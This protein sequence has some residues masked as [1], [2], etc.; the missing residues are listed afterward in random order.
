MGTRLEP[1][2]LAFD[3]SL[4]TVEQMVLLQ[5]DL[6]GE[7]RAQGGVPR[8][9][10]APELRVALRYFPVLDR[11][12]Q[13]RVEETIE[14][15]AGALVPFRVTMRGLRAWPSAARPRLLEVGLGAEAELVEGLYRVF[16]LHLGRLGLSADPRPFQ[17]GVRVGRVLTPSDPVALEALVRSFS[18]TDFG[19]S[20]VRDLMLCRGSLGRR[21]PS[22]EVVRRFSL[23]QRER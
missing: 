7:I 22:W 16:Q 15:I 1:M 14:K 5:E 11:A 6:D 20:Y 19:G 12:L 23:G 13:T 10:P 17:P 4:E 9:V 18:E 8:W 3:V 2:V 21:G